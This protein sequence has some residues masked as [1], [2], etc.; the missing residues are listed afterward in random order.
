VQLV[1]K[2]QLVQLVKLVQLD[3][4]ELLEFRGQPVPPALLG[5]KV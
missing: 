4:K 1:H 5:L 2:V 3:L